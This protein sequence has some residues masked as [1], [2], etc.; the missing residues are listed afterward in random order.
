MN[1][2]AVRHLK[3]SINL[4]IVDVSETRIRIRID[5]TIDVLPVVKTGKSKVAKHV[6]EGAILQHDHHNCVDLIQ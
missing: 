4:M 6:V 2:R 1:Q 5:E 3:R